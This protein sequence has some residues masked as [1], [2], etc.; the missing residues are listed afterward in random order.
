[1]D[2]AYLCDLEQ[3]A[4]RVYELHDDLAERR[5]RLTIDLIFDRDH[6]LVIGLTS[7]LL[8]SI[9]LIPWLGA[10]IVIVGLTVLYIGALSSA[11]WTMTR[12]QQARRR[13]RLESIDQAVRRAI[14]TCPPL[15]AGARALLIR[16]ANLAAIPP[17]ARSVTMLQATL[18]EVL[19]RPDLRGWPFLDDVAMLVEGQNGRT[20]VGSPTS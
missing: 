12:M 6:R 5:T 7:Q 19:A 10:G 11:A 16:L 13:D 8:A 1:M 17:T 15:D 2:A 9:A 20:L 4:R 3:C 14:T 18:R